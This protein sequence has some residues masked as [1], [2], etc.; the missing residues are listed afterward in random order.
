LGGSVGG[1]RL[2]LWGLAFKANTDDM[3]EAPAL[4]FIDEMTAEGAIIVAHDPHA[5]LET[6]R[7]IG[8]R[9]EYAA[10]MYDAV[11]EAD[12]LVVMT[13]WNSYRN[14]DFA[15]LKAALRYPVLID[16]RNLYDPVRLRALGFV[17]DSIGRPAGGVG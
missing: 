16:A 9:I 5:M 3:R 1:R 7:R 8:D 11:A 13:E 15:R 10:T 17:Y 12:A 4:P 14:P 2:A 6:R